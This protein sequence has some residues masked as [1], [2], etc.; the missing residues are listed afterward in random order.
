M[1]SLKG[2]RAPLIL[3]LGLLLTI[4]LPYLFAARAG[5]S[6]YAF[7]G[8]LLNP[9]DGNS[10]LAKM[11]AGWRGEWLF[12]LPY[13]AER[14]SG[15]LLF[16]FYLLLGHTARWLGLPLVLTFHLARLCAAAAL[17]LVLYRFYHAAMSESR[18]ANLAFA[19]GALGSGLGWLALLVG[20][21][22]ADFWV[23][24]AYPFLSAYTNPH[25]PLGLALILY[26]LTPYREGWTKPG[27]ERLFIFLASLSLAIISPFGVVIVV[28]VLGGLLIW[29]MFSLF[30][31]WLSSG[32][33][34]DFRSL[35]DLRFRKSESSYRPSPSDVLYRRVRHLLPILLGGLPLLLYD[36]WISHAD[37]LLAAWNAQNVTPSPPLWDLVVSLSPAL[38]LA[39]PAAWALLRSG[40]SQGRL[41]LTWSVLALVLVYLPFGLQ[42]RFMMGLY[43]PLAGLAAVSID[44]FFSK[45]AVGVYQPGRYFLAVGFLFLLAIPTNLVVLLAARHGVQTYDPNL[46]IS[47]SEARAF[48]WI[49][50]HTPQDAVILAAPETGLYI[51][52][53]TGRRVIY[54]HP[55]ET[56]N[57]AAE[58]EFVLDFYR[59]GEP[60]A[61][62]KT[63]HQADYIFYGPREKEIGP[64]DFLTDL[65]VLYDQA[66]VKIF[67][68]SIPSTLDE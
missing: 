53:R 49:E 46:F 48:R 58:K 33:G 4:S 67:A 65:P 55:F 22:T 41:L 25:F 34:T 61:A 42:R 56:A 1:H 43:I 15:S 37:P 31:G 36:L 50:Q 54:G 8:F 29:E 59:F 2:Y 27:L 35:A 30:T 13:T 16:L 18:Q 7:A 6:D 3:S 5:G 51:P 64:A 68:P 14:G 63:G 9:L 38:I 60:A 45:Q 44:R 21:F 47:K 39:L 12:I 57:A 20:G 66:G 28:T 26:L 32:G 17:L 11:Y 62:F 23:S 40:S 24:E 52:A 19:L 10:Y